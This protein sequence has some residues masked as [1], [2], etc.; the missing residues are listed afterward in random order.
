MKEYQAHIA[1]VSRIQDA[2]EVELLLQ[3][4]T[5]GPRKYDGE[6]VTALI[7]RSTDK[8]PDGDILWVRSP[9]GV[10]NPK[11][12]AIKIVDRIGESVPGRPYSKD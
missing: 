7:Y 11:P 5:P 3:D 8:L 2:Q 1:N 4:L 12:W 9:L 6:I 10:L